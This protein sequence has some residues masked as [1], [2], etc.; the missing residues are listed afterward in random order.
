MQLMGVSGERGPGEQRRFVLEVA[1]HAVGRLEVELPRGAGQRTVDEVLAELV[2][3]IA[4][5]LETARA[6]R[7]QPQQEAE[8]SELTRRLRRAREIGQLTP[9]QVEVLEM[10]ARGKTNKEIAAALSRSEGTVEVHVTNLLRK[11]GATNRAGLVAMF[12]GEL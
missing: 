12:W 5:A 11:Y 8:E 4:I 7:S 1:G 9:R 2:P 6:S 10:V 3:W